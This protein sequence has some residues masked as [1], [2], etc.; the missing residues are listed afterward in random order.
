MSNDFHRLRVF[1]SRPFYTADD[2]AIIVP[3]RDVYWPGF[4]FPAQ[5]ARPD[6]GCIGFLPVFETREAAK[7]YLA[8]R[9]SDVMIF[10]IREVQKEVSA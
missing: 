2:A 8:G 6:D 10:T 4:R 7:A 3:K 5:L 1:A 9:D